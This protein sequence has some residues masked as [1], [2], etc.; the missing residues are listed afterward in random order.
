V[1]HYPRSEEQNA[2]QKGN[3]SSFHSFDE[4]TIDTT[5][6]FTIYTTLICFYLYC[7]F[8]FLALVAA[9]WVAQKIVLF[10]CVRT[11]GLGFGIVRSSKMIIFA[12]VRRFVLFV[13]PLASNHLPFSTQNDENEDDDDECDD[14]SNDDDSNDEDDDH[15]VPTPR[16]VNWDPAGCTGWEFDKEACAS[17]R[18]RKFLR[19][20]FV[21]RAVSVR[22]GVP[23]AP[24]AP[25]KPP[26]V[27]RVGIDV[28]SKKRQCGDD[29]TEEERPLKRLRP[30]P[31]PVPTPTRTATLVS[32]PVPTSVPT[33]DDDD[34]DSLCFS[35]DDEDSLCFSDDDSESESD[36]LFFLDDS[37]CDSD[38]ELLF[39][40][41]LLDSECTEDESE[42]LI[43]QSTDRD[44]DGTPAAPVIV[45]ERPPRRSARIAGKKSGI[46]TNS[47]Q[48][49]ERP[50]PRPTRISAPLRRSARLATKARVSYL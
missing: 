20:P 29:T 5:M 49:V 17:T 50:L 38:M 43:D 28:F 46:C 40:L 14:D 33:S 32:T 10:V 34:E 15:Q 2:Q 37:A 48:V 9:G 6:T 1:E 16:G 41:D 27:G 45:V 11:L 4:D 7:A 13:V 12:F 3:P 19:V 47:C 31:S 39:D 30:S 8:I 24:G 36:S 18:G 44:G 22:L 23:V 26:R 21:A 25:V 35:D 42:S